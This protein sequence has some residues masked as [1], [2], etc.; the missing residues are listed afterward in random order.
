M[1]SGDNNLD[2]H[3]LPS[4]VRSRVRVGRSI[5]FFKYGFEFQS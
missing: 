2:A 4:C 5:E 3:R 1:K